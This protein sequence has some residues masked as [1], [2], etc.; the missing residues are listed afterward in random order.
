M[1]R[2]VGKATTSTEAR[3]RA[4]ADVYQAVLAIPSYNNN[5]APDEQALASAMQEP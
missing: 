2:R 4:K 3:S 1:L 5:N